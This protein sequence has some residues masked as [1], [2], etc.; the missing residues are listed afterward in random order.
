MSVLLV[1][2]LGRGGIAQCTWAWA[3]SLRRS[4]RAVTVVTRPD[5]ELRSSDGIDVVTAG[6]AR[7]AI[8][9][10]LQLVHA[11]R[12]A[13]LERRPTTVVIQ[14][15]VLAPAELAVSD[16]AHRT[17]AHLVHVV[18]DHRLH[19][20]AAGTS[21]GL[22]R[23]LARADA[24]VA[25]TEFVA[26]HVRALAR[27]S[28]D[29]VP[30]P[31]QSGMFDPDHVVPDPAGPPW[32]ALHFG[33]LHR[34][35][36]GADTFSDLAASGLADWCFRAVGA[37][38]S[39]TADVEAVTGFVEPHA[40]VEEVDRARAT[41][42]PYRL[43]S[44]S[45]AVVLSQARR[46]VP[47]ASAIGGIPEQIDHGVDGLLLPADAGLDAWR[48]ALQRLEDRSEWD[49]MASAGRHRVVHAFARFRSFVDGLT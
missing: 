23:S 34:S 46:S 39:P 41:V 33:V 42:L 38:A 12:R 2:W 16:A 5:R 4:G 22:R 17:G 27:R 9:A 24:L 14:N 49:R 29:V 6:S 43:A 28:V 36:K 10:H 35:Y 31:M 21:L 26:A 44:Q 47:I 8:V 40:L 1:D 45:G 11:A 37:G 3:E 25:H 18:H 13:I 19:T 15:F 48:G 30:L 20:R 7:Q 32:V